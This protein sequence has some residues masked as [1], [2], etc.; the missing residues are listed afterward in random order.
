MSLA[1][2]RHAMEDAGHV[3]PS[4]FPPGF[5]RGNVTEIHAAPWVRFSDAVIVW[6]AI[7]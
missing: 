6:K 3:E 4:S 1:I 7:G 5:L 2:G